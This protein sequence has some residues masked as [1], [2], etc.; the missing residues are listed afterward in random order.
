V[1]WIRDLDPE[2]S[3]GGLGIKHPRSATLPYTEHIIHTE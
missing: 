2:W 1:L 3:N